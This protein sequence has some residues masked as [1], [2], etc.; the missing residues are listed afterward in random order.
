MEFLAGKVF[1]KLTVIRFMGSV[2]RSGKRRKTWLCKCECGDEKVIEHDQLTR[3][4][5]VSCGCYRK[6][7][8]KIHNTKHGLRQTKEYRVWAGIIQR[9]NNPNCNRYKDYGGRG[10]TVCDRWLKFENFI[11]DM[12]MKPSP[13]H[14]MDRIDN[15][16]NY[17][18]INCRWA[19]DEEQRRNRRDNRWIEY[20]GQ[21]KI[22]ADWAKDLGI[23][24][25]N[26]ASQ[27]NLRTLEECF[28]KA[29]KV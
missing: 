19:T 29:G 18:P 25:E 22:V 8:G 10:I 6:K 12:G 13:K 7:I 3:G 9:C 16:G 27:L 15:D 23:T 20:N 4:K 17:E 11:A 2:I 26:L 14:T 5:S 24:R 28:K 1:G 21:R